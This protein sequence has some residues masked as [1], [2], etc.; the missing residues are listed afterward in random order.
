MKKIFPKQTIIKTKHF[1]VH[2]DWEV[3]IPGFFIIASNRDIKSV[4]ELSPQES[5]EFIKLLIKIRQ[6]M[7]EILK[8]KQVYLFQDESSSHGFHLW[9]LPRYKWMDKIGQKIESI[10]P[11]INYAKANLQAEKS[12][13]KVR[14]MVT[15]MKNYMVEF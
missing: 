7:K 9:I 15:K 4:S 13:K 1:D 2:Q 11:I 12:F 3:P 8:I 5:E 14:E 10:R 6:G